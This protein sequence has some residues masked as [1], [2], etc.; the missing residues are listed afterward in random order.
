M[1]QRRT[2]IKICLAGFAS[3][4]RRWGSE[5]SP[6]SRGAAHR[7]DGR[8]R[9]GYLETSETVKMV[10]RFFTMHFYAMQKVHLHST[11]TY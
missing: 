8:I 9:V 4:A 7:P 11:G 1:N 10:G 5:T 2:P 6:E 3:E